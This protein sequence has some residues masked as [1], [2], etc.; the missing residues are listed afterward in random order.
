ME[1]NMSAI[2]QEWKSLSVT[3]R[4][5]PEAVSMVMEK[6]QYHCQEWISE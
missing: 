3:K 4:E 5:Q 6:S 1:G 2:V